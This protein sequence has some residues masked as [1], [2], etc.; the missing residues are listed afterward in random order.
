M[1]GSVTGVLS[2]LSAR[3]NNAS[4][5]FS[6][7][8]CSCEAFQR[9]AVPRCAIPVRR[10]KVGGAYLGVRLSLSPSLFVEQR[11]TRDDAT[12]TVFCT[13]VGT[14]RRRLG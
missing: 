9:R 11:S 5:V 12:A 1:M 6:L 2:C 7:L 14:T 10:A 13:A 3:P 4:A 8:R